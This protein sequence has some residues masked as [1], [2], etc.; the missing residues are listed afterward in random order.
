MKL[1]ISIFLILD[2]LIV[3]SQAAGSLGP[4]MPREIPNPAFLS[5]WPV[6]LGRSWLFSA[7][8]LERSPAAY[9]FGGVLWLFSGILLVAAGLGVWDY[10]VSAQWW[11]LLAIGGAAISLFMLAIY[12]HPMMI[13]GIAASLGHSARPAVGRVAARD[14]HPV[15]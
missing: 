14:T 9:W 12:F 2:G 6:N 10:I 11:R 3:A 13:L 15:V 5:W 4:T 1:A 7:L 8:G